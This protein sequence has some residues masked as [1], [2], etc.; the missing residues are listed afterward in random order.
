MTI[1][2]GKCK[3]TDLTLILIIRERQFAELV[4]I[5]VGIELEDGGSRDL[6]TTKWTAREGCTIRLR[7][8]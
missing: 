4:C 2:C 5:E 6:A 7:Q 8:N 3:I 1:M